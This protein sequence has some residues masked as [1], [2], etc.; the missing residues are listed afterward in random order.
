MIDKQWDVFTQVTLDALHGHPLLGM[1]I[2][3]AGY[4]ISHEDAA[5]LM[6]EL[7]GLLDNFMTKYSETIREHLADTR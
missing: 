5:T 4:A 6:P 7:R 2:I 1:A 3:A